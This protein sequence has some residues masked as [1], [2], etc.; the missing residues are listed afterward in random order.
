[1]ARIGCTLCNGGSPSAISMIVMPGQ[2]Q[3]VEHCESNCELFRLF[4]SNQGGAYLNSIDLLCRRIL[5]LE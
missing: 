1:M 4:S 5:F 3:W 2:N